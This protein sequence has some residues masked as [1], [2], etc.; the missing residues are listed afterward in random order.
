MPTRAEIEA[1]VLGVTGDPDTGVVR[2][3]TPAL[4]DAVDA[5]CNPRGKGQGRGGEPVTTRVI[6]ADE[7]R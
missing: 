7:T 2:D 6:E 4:V 3:I 1:A 5:L